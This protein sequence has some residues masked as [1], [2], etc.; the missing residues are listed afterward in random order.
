VFLTHLHADFVAGHL[1]DGMQALAPR[2]DLSAIA[3]L[4]G[5]I[6]AWTSHG[7]R[8]ATAHAR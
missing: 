6:A 8:T 7:L 3:D 2:P 1:A 4:A 5:G